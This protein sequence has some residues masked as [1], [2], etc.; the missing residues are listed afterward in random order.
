MC[1]TINLIL[2][3]LLFIGCSAKYVYYHDYPDCIKEKPKVIHCCDASGHVSGAKPWIFG[4]KCCCTPTREMFEINR[5]EKTVENDITYN[6]YISL[7]RKKGIVTNLDETSENFSLDYKKHVVLGGN[8][9]KTPFPG[10]TDYELIVFGIERSIYIIKE[11][12]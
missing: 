5:K 3:C 7:Y 6:D 10:T 4:G 8:S 9:M 12:F 1:K 2:G 11:K